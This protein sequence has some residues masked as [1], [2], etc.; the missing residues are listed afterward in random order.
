MIGNKIHGVIITEF[1]QRYTGVNA[2]VTT[3]FRSRLKN[4]NRDQK[5]KPPIQFGKGV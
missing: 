2:F 1:V 4:I 3:D 5:Y